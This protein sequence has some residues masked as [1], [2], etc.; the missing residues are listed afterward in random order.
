MIVHYYA[1]AAEAA[2]LAEETIEE[3]PG[4][5]VQGAADRLVARHPDLAPIIGVCGFFIDG[6]S[7]RRDAVLPAGAHLDV[8]PPFAGG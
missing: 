6:A 2:G 5:A 8:L 4:E 3:S 7:A 1:G